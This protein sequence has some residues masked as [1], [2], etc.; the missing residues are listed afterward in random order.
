MRGIGFQPV[1]ISWLQERMALEPSI[2]AEWRPSHTTKTALVSWCNQS[3]CKLEKTCFERMAYS[4][5]RR[6][7][8]GARV[9]T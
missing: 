8:R 1:R 2:L 7:L 5:S 3:N 4:E 9:S 6:G